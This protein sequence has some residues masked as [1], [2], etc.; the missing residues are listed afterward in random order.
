VKL[1]LDGLPRVLLGINVERLDEPEFI[2]ALQDDFY[3]VLVQKLYGTGT[4]DDAI[5]RARARLG[6]TGLNLPL[7][8]DAERSLPPNPLDSIEPEVL[9]LMRRAP[10]TPPPGPDRP[11]IEKLSDNL[12]SLTD[13][14]DIEAVLTAQ[15]WMRGGGWHSTWASMTVEERHA[16]LAPKPVRRR[17]PDSECTCDPAPRSP[18]PPKRTPSPCPQ[19]QPLLPGL[20]VG[21]TTALVDAIATWACV[22][23]SAA[24]PSYEPRCPH[25]GFQDDAA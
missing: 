15:V 14:D 1:R 13:D 7:F 20:D 11:L 23:C 17:A 6:E 2:E 5:R 24:V 21:T 12:D 18:A 16:L 9:A 22:N 19:H 8:P 25:C 4:G 3:E 10:L